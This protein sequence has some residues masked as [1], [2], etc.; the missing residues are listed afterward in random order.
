MIYR[1]TSTMGLSHFYPRYIAQEGPASKWNAW[2]GSECRG[3]ARNY[4]VSTAGSIT[5]SH[6]SSREGT[7]IREGLTTNRSYRPIERGWP[8]IS[9]RE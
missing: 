5:L 3:I 1:G 2:R 8:D 9:E 6:S 4:F 7:V